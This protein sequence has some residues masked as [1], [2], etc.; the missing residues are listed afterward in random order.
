M[1]DTRTFEMNDEQIAKH[2][3]FVDSLTNAISAHVERNSDNL[4]FMQ[5]S[6]YNA[7]VEQLTASVFASSKINGSLTCFQIMSE[8]T[9]RLL[10]L[11][12]ADDKMSL[13]QDLN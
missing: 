8:L 4:E 3:L 6:L 5:Q 1:D 7:F 2:K 11:A 10:E 9:N 12:K 13:K